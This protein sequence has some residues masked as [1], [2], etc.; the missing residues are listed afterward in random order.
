M[1]SKRKMIQKEIDRV[2]DQ[3]LNTT[4]EVVDKTIPTIAEGIN[5]IVSGFT[6]SIGETILEGLAKT[7]E[8][9]RKRVKKQPKQEVNQ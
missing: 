4:K 9:K 2:R 6:S 8:R 7:I 3:V 1:A 5:K